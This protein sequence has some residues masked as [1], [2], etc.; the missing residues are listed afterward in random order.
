MDEAQRTQFITEY[1]QLVRKFV[2]ASPNTAQDWQDLLFIAEN[3]DPYVPLIWNSDW[4]QDPVKDTVE[5]VK[6]WVGSLKLPH[7]ILELADIYVVYP[8]DIELARLLTVG[9]AKSLL[10]GKGY[11]STFELANDGRVFNT[12]VRTQIE[13]WFKK[14]RP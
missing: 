6:M 12:Q 7:N 4:N 13:E 3:S 9:F 8:D 5:Q 10:V 11:R 14:G 2:P 1:A